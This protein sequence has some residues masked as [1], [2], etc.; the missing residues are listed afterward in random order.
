[1]LERGNYSSS[2]R[3][4]ANQRDLEPFTWRHYENGT[5]VEFKWLKWNSSHVPGRI[6][7]RLTLWVSVTHALYRC[8]HLYQ[9]FIPS[10]AEM[11]WASTDC[12]RFP[13]EEGDCLVMQGAG[14]ARVNGSY[15]QTGAFNGQPMFENPENGLQVWFNGNWRVGKTNDYYYT[16]GL[17]EGPWELATIHLNADAIV[18]TPCCHKT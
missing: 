14:C 1:M 16:S 11:Y 10:T 2:G 7:N 18:P 6:E 4:S 8:E 12:I 13:G 15:K 9:V 5:A 17:L 3:F